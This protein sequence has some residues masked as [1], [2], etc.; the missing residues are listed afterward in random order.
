ML[1]LYEMMTQAQNGKAMEVVAQQFGLAQEQ[2]AKAMAALL[3]AFSEGLKRSA[4]NPYDFGAFLSALTSGEHAKYFEDVTKAFTPQGINAGNN[5]LG[6]LF[7]SKEVSRAIAAQAAQMTGIGQEIYKQ[8]LPAMANTL[9]GG[10]FKQT[11][12][13]FAGASAEVNPFAAM[14][15]QWMEMMGMAKKPEPV[16]NPFNNPFTQA[17]F[18]GDKT[19]KAP[20][21]FADNPFAKAFQDMMAT[22]SGGAAA[23]SEKAQPKTETPADSLGK[24][25]GAM[26][27]TGI[28]MQKDY[29]K[30][31]ESIFETMSRPASAPPASGKPEA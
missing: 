29:Q 5:V 22:M 4:A 3:P 21:L 31:I 25:V 12:G 7:G 18:G 30:N 8:M 24:L 11:F 6:Q 23:P 1:P 26:F 19:E 20:D 28:E 13:P 15:Q 2:A 10:L 27:D 17:F 14:T 9:M 16:T